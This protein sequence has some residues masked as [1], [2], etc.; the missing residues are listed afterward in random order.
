MTWGSP[1]ATDFKIVSRICGVSS[2]VVYAAF[3]YHII[4]KEFEPRY[5]YIVPLID[6]G[7]SF[8]CGLAVLMPEKRRNEE[9]LSYLAFLNP[10]ANGTRLLIWCKLI[11]FWSTSW[12][13]ILIPIYFLCA[14][15]EGAAVVGAFISVAWAFGSGPSK[16]GICTIIL[17]VL[18]FLL[19]FALL[20]IPLCFTIL[21]TKRNGTDDFKLPL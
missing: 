19:I 9:K 11:H 15:I 13:V 1:V 21:L 2:L 12:G 14:I 20:S 17:A 18:T 5:T 3:I 6:T 8:L 4:I 10:L 16:K 7:I